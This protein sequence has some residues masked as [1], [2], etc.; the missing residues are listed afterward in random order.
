MS[1]GVVTADE[2]SFFLGR[3]ASGTQGQSEMTLGGSDSSKYTGS[4]T[5]VPVTTKGYW[6]TALDNVQVSG[7]SAGPTTKGQSAIDTGTTILLA[8]TDAALAI[9]ALIPGAFPVPLASGSPTITVFAYPCNTKKTVSVGFA[10]KQFAINPLDMSLGALT[11]GFAS[12]VGNHKLLE[13]LL[14]PL[15]GGF[16][17]ASI[18]GADIDPTEN[19]Y[20]VGD[21]FI[22]NW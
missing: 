14:G 11:P 21:T 5:Q 13:T 6:Q 1:Q 22:K 4:F 10:G 19:L 2:F 9:F 15:G 16:C 12:F 8:P 20:V 7:V 17:L 3:A 18:A